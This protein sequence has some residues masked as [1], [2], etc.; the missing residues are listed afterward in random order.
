[1]YIVSYLKHNHTLGYDFSNNK[2]VK[3][4]RIKNNWFKFRGSPSSKL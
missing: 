3:F 2:I 1:M 4:E